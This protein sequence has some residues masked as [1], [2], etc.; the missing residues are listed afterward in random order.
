M[1][2]PR[3]EIGEDVE[4]YNGGGQRLPATIQQIHILSSG[5]RYDI[6]NYGETIKFVSEDALY[7]NGEDY[8][9]KI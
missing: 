8:R 9:Y 2:T 6:Q 7:K 1:Q 3:F 5:T 4:F